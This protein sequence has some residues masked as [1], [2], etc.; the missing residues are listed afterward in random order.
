MEDH[1][2]RRT[3]ENFAAAA[4]RVR[5]GDVDGV[6][7]SCQAGTLIEQFWSPAMNFRTDGYGGSLE[8]RMRFGLETL[9]AV[10]PGRR[11]RLCGRHP[12]ARR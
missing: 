1:D 8:N 9:E 7:I 4:R 3:V 6:E 5:D 2:I 10:A 12:H 11:R